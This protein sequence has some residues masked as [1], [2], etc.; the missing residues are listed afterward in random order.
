MDMEGPVNEATAKPPSV[1][2][3]QQHGK[4][5]HPMDMEGP[6]IEATSEY[7]SAHPLL[8]RCN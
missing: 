2:A 3:L 1:H 7:P 6:V 4:S 8:Q 5:I